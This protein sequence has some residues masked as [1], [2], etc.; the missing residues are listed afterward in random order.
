MNNSQYFALSRVF[1]AADF[2][3]YLLR[4]LISYYQFQQVEHCNSQLL[5]L[6]MVDV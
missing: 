1:P 6:Q 3:S 5:E 2:I 4:N